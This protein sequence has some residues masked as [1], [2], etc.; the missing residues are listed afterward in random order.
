MYAGGG[1]YAI[2]LADIVTGWLIGIN[3]RKVA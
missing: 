3:L 1:D 2:G